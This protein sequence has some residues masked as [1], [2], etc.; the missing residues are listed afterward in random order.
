MKLSII[1]VSYNEIQYLSQAIESCL[2]QDCDFPFEIIIGDDGSTDGSIDVIQQ[3]R[4]KYPDK[5]RYF[6]MDRSDAVDVI[7]SIR[8]SNVL[9]RGFQEAVGAYIT[10]LSGDDLLLDTNKLSVQVE[11]LEKHPHFASTYTDFKMFWNDGREIPVVMRADHCRAVFLSSLYMHISCFVFR[12]AALDYLLDRFCDDTGLI[13]SIFCAG[14]SKRLPQ[15]AFGYRQRDYSIIQSADTLELNILELA[16]CQDVVNR[17]GLKSSTLSRFAKPM[18]YVFDR[19]EKLQD[20][21]YRKYLASCS[22]YGHN[23][24]GEIAQFD[25]LSTA[26]QRKLKQLMLTGMISHGLYLVIRKIETGIR[27]ICPQKD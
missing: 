14:K 19:R 22:R 25:S 8:V 26:E 18:R 2:N 27:L 10:V 7:P 21:K 9:K 6:V 15:L 13:F 3:Y 20:E 17:S 1:I 11:Y 4:E 5:I 16:L 24:L 23:Y 12:R